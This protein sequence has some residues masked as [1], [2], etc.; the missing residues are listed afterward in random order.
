MVSRAWTTRHQKLIRSMAT[1]S[2]PRSGWVARR[3]G[4]EDA[5][6]N[7]GVESKA[8]VVVIVFVV[9]VVVVVVVMVVVVVVVVR[10][11]CGGR[12]GEKYYGAS[13]QLCHEFG[14]VV[15]FFAFL[16]GIGVSLSMLW[17]RMFLQEE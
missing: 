2:K 13:Q 17:V 9:V 8:L 6:C 4:G 15:F 10:G 12:R 5:E 11:G 3:Q 7:E 14:H 16:M 1:K